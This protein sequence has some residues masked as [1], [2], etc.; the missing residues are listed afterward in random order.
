MPLG[1]RF[2]WPSS[3]GRFTTWQP[4]P[5]PAHAPHAGHRA[6][7]TAGERTYTADGARG[8]Q[9]AKTTAVL[10]RVVLPLMR[11][12]VHAALFNQSCNVPNCF[13]LHPAKC[14]SINP[15]ITVVQE[16]VHPV[17]TVY[18]SITAHFISAT[19]AFTQRDVHALIHHAT[20]RVETFWETAA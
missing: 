17:V 19:R 15:A 12:G 20:P 10:A 6:A 2:N 9:V 4:Q 3:A 14:V 18:S 7:T 16:L 13:Q 1:R 8:Q 5:C 11:T